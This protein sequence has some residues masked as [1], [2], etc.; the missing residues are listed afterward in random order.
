VADISDDD[1]QV[2]IEVFNIGRG[3]VGGSA[4]M[5][6]GKKARANVKRALE[7]VVTRHQPNGGAGVE[8][9]SPE[10]TDSA[11]AAIAWV[12]WHH[13]GGSS[14]IGQPLRFALG[15]GDHE[16]LP[17][18]RIAEAKRWAALTGS[19]TEDFH[20]AGAEDAR[21]AALV[22]MLRDALAK[23]VCE[24]GKPEYRE[25]ARSALAAAMSDQNKGKV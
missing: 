12:L 4:L 17:A 14:A 16:E 25:Q 1:V 23:L 8:E 9:M 3:V 24:P 19:K 11:R 15:M 7:K 10:F 22:E 18:W 13:Q 6:Q 21:D 2:F 20:R 5:L